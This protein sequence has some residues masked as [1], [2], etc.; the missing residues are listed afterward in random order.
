MKVTEILTE[1]LGKKDTYAILQDFVKFA[2]QHLEL[3]SLPKLEFIFNSK[4]SVENRS[5]GG[6]MPGAKHIIITVQNRHIMDVCRTLAHELVHYSQDLKNQLEDENAGATGSPQENEANAEAAV[7]MRNW[8]KKHPDLFE[9]ESINEGQEYLDKPTPSAEEI[10]AKHGM[11]EAEFIQQM[12]MGIKDEMEHT[13]NV[14][15]AMEIALD[16]INERP[17]YYTQIQ[18][19]LR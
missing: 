2:A 11:S 18:Q 5:F 4:R 6:Y 1:G 16:H 3:S 12:R 7:I 14:K 17:D 9:K 10:I 19:A 15:I 8:G 13:S